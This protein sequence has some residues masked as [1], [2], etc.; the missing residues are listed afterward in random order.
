MVDRPHA[1]RETGMNIETIRKELRE[2]RFRPLAVRLSDGST[3][4]V[5]HPELI[6]MSPRAVFVGKEDGDYEIIDP[7]HV[8][9]IDRSVPSR[10]RRGNGR[11]SS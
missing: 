7:M 2:E 4:H 9:A 8:V 11:S 6:G 1:V 5:A 10:K 3:L